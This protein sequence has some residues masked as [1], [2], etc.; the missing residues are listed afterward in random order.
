MGCDNGKPLSTDAPNKFED[1]LIKVLRVFANLSLSEDVG[2]SIAANLDLMASI[3]DILGNRGNF[4]L[5]FVLWCP[6]V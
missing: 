1:V 3:V 6:D 2:T 5:F 4:T